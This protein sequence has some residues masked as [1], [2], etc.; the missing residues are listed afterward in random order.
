MCR[1]MSFHPEPGSA[2]ESRRSAVLRFCVF[3][4]PFLRDLHRAPSQ[5]AAHRAS[6]IDQPSSAKFPA[7]TA[8]AAFS[9]ILA[10]RL[11]RGLI[12]RSFGRWLA[13]HGAPIAFALG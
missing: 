12:A 4:G 3:R 6:A 7:R 13:G 11:P 1:R 8:D 9:Y 5:R 2:K 10:D